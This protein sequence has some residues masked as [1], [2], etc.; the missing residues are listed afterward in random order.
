MAFCLT[1]IG[2]IWSMFGENTVREGRDASEMDSDREVL[3]SVIRSF[4]ND[5]VEGALVLKTERRSYD[6]D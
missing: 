5:L 2:H 6:S 4:C 1:L 3:K